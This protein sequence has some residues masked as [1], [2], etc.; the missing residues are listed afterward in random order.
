[1]FTLPFAL[2]KDFGLVTGPVMGATSWLLYGI[3]QI[4]YSIEDPF[5][6][7]LRLSTLCDTIYRDCM[8]GTDFMRRRATAFRVDEEA[9]E[10]SKLDS[11]A[12]P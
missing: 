11:R 7:S 2:I 9:Q 5:Q 6:G 12:T 8:Y 10:W 1:L 4:G 3:Y